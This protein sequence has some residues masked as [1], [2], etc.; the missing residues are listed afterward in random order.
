MATDHLLDFFK[1]YAP[2]PIERAPIAV[3]APVLASV[4]NGN[5]GAAVANDA[6]R[7]H[8]RPHHL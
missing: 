3:H 4:A 7:C 1:V 8:Q 5:G 6:P 2:A